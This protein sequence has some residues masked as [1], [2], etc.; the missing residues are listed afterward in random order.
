MKAAQ[1]D[2]DDEEAV[3]ELMELADDENITWEEE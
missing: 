2:P 3:A 1:V